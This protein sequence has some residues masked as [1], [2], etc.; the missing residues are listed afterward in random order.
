MSPGFRSTW[1]R[2]EK[3]VSKRPSTQKFISSIP[4]CVRSS[5][6][7]SIS[8]RIS[9]ALG[10]ISENTDGTVALLPKETVQTFKARFPIAI[11]PL[12]K[13]LLTR[14]AFVR[15]KALDPEHSTVNTFWDH[16]RRDFE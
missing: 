6:Y 8:S 16:V 9:I 2:R 3:C 15:L 13:P 12:D 5:V 14:T 4:F 11:I 1:S 7:A 10:M